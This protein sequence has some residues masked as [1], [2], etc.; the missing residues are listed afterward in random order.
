MTKTFV[1]NRVGE[2]QT[3]SLPDKWRH[4]PSDMNPA[5]IPTR[6][7][8]IDSLATNSLWGNGPEFL[9]KEEIHWPKRF[10]P[11][12]TNEDGK[13]EFKKS[14]INNIAHVTTKEGKVI[15]CPTRFS[16]GEIK[17]GFASLINLPS[18]VYQLLK[19]PVSK[20]YRLALLYQIRK[21]QRADFSLDEI[22][23]IVS[24]K[25]KSNSLSP[26]VDESGVI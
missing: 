17:D 2:I 5:D 6:F 26:F 13:D 19:L 24:K 11:A 10:V 21:A 15:L 7:P 22:R 12:T 25:K 1:S 8:S 4:V 9:L 14:L 18:L 16:V 20:V 23:D 3:Q